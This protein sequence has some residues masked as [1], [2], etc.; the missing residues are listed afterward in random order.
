MDRSC[1]DI[2]GE[3]NIG[4]G[5]MKNEDN[6]CILF[7]PGFPCGLAMVADGI[8]GHRDGELASMFCCH[9][10]LKGFMRR[11][12]NMRGAEAA[13]D[14]LVDTL[15]DVNA[16]LFRRNEF[17]RR[18]RPMGSTAMC[19]VFTERELVWCGAGDSRLYEF[20][21]A[22]GEL[23]QLSSDDVVPGTSALFRAV[24]I[25]RRF[26]PED[27]EEPERDEEELRA[28]A[29]A[30][31]DRLEELGLLN[32]ES[33]AVQVARH[34]AAKGYGARKIRD[35][36]FRRGVPREYWDAALE[37]L[38]DPTQAIEAFLEKKLRGWTGDPK[39]LKRAADA[40]ARR[41]FSWNDISAA[42]RRYEERIG[43]D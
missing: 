5:R 20:S 26:D 28:R 33:Y 41:G 22:S 14:F 29:D 30:V 37:G 27:G 21:P 35:E 10:M 4:A 16:R 12:R 9:G 23:R 3:T 1:F 43:E 34:Y 31:A 13:C 39:E 6:Y 19:A 38:D 8:G 18:E 42:L 24:G 11:G 7:P 40:L 15:R 36:L 32:D 2:A 17:E 25:R